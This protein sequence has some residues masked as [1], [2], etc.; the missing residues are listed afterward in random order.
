MVLIF[1]VIVAVGAA[2]II[3]A[4]KKGLN[5]MEKDG[6]YP[7]GHYMG[8]GMAMGIPLGIPIGLALGNISLGP[9]IGAGFG[10]VFGAALEEKYKDKL[11][12]LTEEEKENK[13]KLMLITIGI[14][15]LGALVFLAF[16]LTQGS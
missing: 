9:A 11:R 4:R 3:M 8:I 7:K 6:K 16:F 1:L 15:L 2:A 5:A 14:L 12:P 10:L 13:K